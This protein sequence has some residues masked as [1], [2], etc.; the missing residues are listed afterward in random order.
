M[1]WIE[2]LNEEEEDVEYGVTQFADMTPAEFRAS[3]GL[4]VPDESVLKARRIT[5]QSARQWSQGELAGLPESYDWRE[6][7]AV[8]DVKDQ[9][10]CG[11]CWAFSAIANIEGQWFL[12]GNA[13]TSL[14]EEQLVSVRNGR[15]WLTDL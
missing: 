10:S 11:S 5:H 4:N 14:S 12:A 8:T 3:L 1:R 13:L 15:S 2:K 9:S 6:H 7:G